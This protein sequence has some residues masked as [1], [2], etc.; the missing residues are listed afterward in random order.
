MVE[1]GPAVVEV[2]EEAVLALVLQQ[3]QLLPQLLNV[4]V[5]QHQHDAHGAANFLALDPLQLACVLAHVLQQF[6]LS[7]RC[8]SGLVRVQV[9]QVALALLEEEVRVPG[10]AAED[11]E[12]EAALHEGS[13]RIKVLGFRF[14]EADSGHEEDDQVFPVLRDFLQEEAAVDAHHHAVAQVEFL[15]HALD[16]EAGLAGRIPLAGLLVRKQLGRELG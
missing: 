3:V 14:I 4:R 10:S 6:L 16:E 5:L 7:L 12:A 8:L 11:A 13:Q 9:A 15:Q 2:D 1:V